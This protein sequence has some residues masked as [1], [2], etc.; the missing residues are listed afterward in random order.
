LIVDETSTDVANVA[1][2]LSV[3]VST[4][5]T[6]F[7]GK[8]MTYDDSV[9]ISNTT[10]I[11]AITACMSSLE[12]EWR[13][14]VS[15]TSDNGSYVVKAVN[16]LKKSHTGFIPLRCLSHGLALM[17]GAIFDE[18]D[19]VHDFLVRLR[20]YTRK[21]GHLEA[22]R[23]LLRK[24]LGSGCLRI[25]GFVDQRWGTCAEA[26]VFVDENYDAIASALEETTKQ[27]KLRGKS[28][29]SAEGL[30][31]LMA[32]ERLAFCFH[33]VRRL[34]EPFPSMLQLS[35]ADDTITP[36]FLRR[37]DLLG[38]TF[39]DFTRKDHAEKLVDCDCPE[40]DEVLSSVMTACQVAHEKYLKYVKPAVYYA[41]RRCFFIPPFAIHA[42]RLGE[43]ATIS[44]V[45]ERI[46]QSTEA[47][48]EFKEYLHRCETVAECDAPTFWREQ[49]ADLPILAEASSR[50][51]A[52]SIT[53]A[54][55]ERTFATLRL[56]VGAERKSLKDD[57]L[58]AQMFLAA[59]ESHWTDDVLRDICSRV[60][61]APL[62]RVPPP[63]T[64]DD[65]AS[66]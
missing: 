31:A 51:L 39:K 16:E 38:S 20:Q 60:D 15:V 42:A 25:L 44:D 8:V 56:M 4:A 26:S 27:R 10:V 50:F 45:S 19:C 9:S 41:L 64:E 65:A 61:S 12:L 35:Q 7:L 24:S 22:R 47:A 18:F 43:F 37:T 30:L 54:P 34:V 66:K 13:S 11:D 48:I 53:G 23:H 3:V 5:E 14:C 46:Q 21:G 36:A 59:N 55:V 1:A 32:S 49:K 2:V 6:K 52:M 63:P 62:A 29:G 57:Y 58:R 40:R 33:V 28:A 17:A